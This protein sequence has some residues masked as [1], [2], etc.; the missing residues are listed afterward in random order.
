MTNT[1][2]DTDLDLD[3]ILA[4]RWVTATDFTAEEFARAEQLYRERRTHDDRLHAARA[5]R[6]V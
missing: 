5:R 1:S 4:A 2:L 3:V 6:P